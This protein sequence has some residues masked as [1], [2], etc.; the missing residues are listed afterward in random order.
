LESLL[1]SVSGIRGVVGK[2]LT[3]DV[4]QRYAAA[5]GSYLKG[6]KVVIGRD[7]RSTGPMIKAAATAGLLSAGCDVIDIGICPTPT[8]EMAV[9][10]GGFSGG[11]SVTASHNPDRYNALKLIGARGLFLSEKQGTRVKAI[12]QKGQ[13]RPASWERVGSVS[14]EDG[15]VD[16]HIKEIL[17]LDIISVPTIRRRKLKVVVDC[18]GGAAGIAAFDFFSRIGVKSEI[19]NV[20]YD[21]RFPRGPEPVPLNLRDL[22][23]MVRKKRADLGLAFDPDADRLAI[24]SE[25]GQALGEEFTLALSA[26]YILGRER[27][28]MVVNLS[29]SLMNEFV[30]REAGVRLYR[31]KVGERN[32]TEKLMR[33]KGAVGGE[34]NGGLIYPGLH[35]GRDAFLAAAVILQYLASSGK[36]MSS[37]AGELPRYTMLKKRLKLSGREI[38]TRTK[39]ISKALPPGKMDLTDGVRVS[40]K[41]WWVHIRPS[42][43]EPITRLVAEAPSPGTARQLAGAVLS[44][45]KR[46]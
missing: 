13:Y 18:G 24:V 6:G 31:T 25:E 12:Y 36:K 26:R 43:T 34:G 23:A 40:G 19:I 5:F 35:W 30:A 20:D 45:F 9:G 33:V 44:V 7:T 37:L 22:C 27:G 15:W 17:K 11:I 14:E 32:V 21:G 16:T 29:S 39:A 38:S 1:V 8:V 42:N 41:N 3:A 10:R 2:A 46:K 28:P 4:A